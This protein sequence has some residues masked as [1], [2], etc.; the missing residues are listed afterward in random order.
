MN[1][2]GMVC[3]AQHERDMLKRA[4]KIIHEY[5]ATTIKGKRGREKMIAIKCDNFFRNSFKTLFVCESRSRWN[6]KKNGEAKRDCCWE[7]ENHKS[8]NDGDRT[9]LALHLTLLNTH[10]NCKSRCSV[11]A[12]V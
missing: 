1:E 6:I 5:P 10:K 7:F 3:V 2:C 11:A 4:K 12:A 8:N 9:A